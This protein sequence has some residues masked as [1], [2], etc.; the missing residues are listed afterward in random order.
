MNHPDKFITYE[1]FQEKEN[2]ISVK[3]WIL[4]QVRK[5]LLEFMLAA[6]QRS[7]D[8]IALL[9]VVLETQYLLLF[10]LCSSCFSLHVLFSIATIGM[11]NSKASK[12]WIFV[13]VCFSSNLKWFKGQN[14]KLQ[15][16]EKFILKVSFLLL[17]IDRVPIWFQFLQKP[18]MD[19]LAEANS[20]Q[21]YDSPEKVS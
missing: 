16:L 8:F 19:R 14:R 1:S 15:V 7:P 12:E 9:K 4:L 20:G 6:F 3:L 11:V 21:A 5:R 2:L 13:C 17:F 18:I 10:S